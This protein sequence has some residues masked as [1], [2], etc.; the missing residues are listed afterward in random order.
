M[1]K[2]QKNRL[3]ERLPPFIAAKAKANIANNPAI[4]MLKVSHQVIFMK[5]DW[6]SL[7]LNDKKIVDRYLLREQV[8]LSDYNFTNLWMWNEARSYHLA[9]ADGDLCI[10]HTDPKA[11]EIYLMPLGNPV[12]IAAIERLYAEQVKVRKPFAMRA[13]SEEVV[14]H[15][16]KLS[17]SYDLTEE[18]HRFDYVYSY[19]DLANLP[20]NRYQA[21]RNLIHQFERE[22]GLNYRE[23]DKSNLTKIIDCEEIWYKEH[24]MRAED[25]KTEHFAALKALKDFFSL[26][27]KGGALFVG[28]GAVAYSFAEYITKNEL[29]IHVEKALGNYKGAY[30]AINQELLKHFSPV[31]YVN[32]EESLG[33]PQLIKVKDSYHP[34]KF[35][36]KYRINANVKNT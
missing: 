13:I 18:P 30:Q 14:H 27:L 1:P 36:K 34:L 20:G 25:P 3:I 16:K 10:R 8:Q 5:L 12:P 15:L 11:G 23:I 17:F 32:R 33:L 28:E 24:M 31:E 35:L 4:M 26:G 9:E 21:K 2:A 29:L 22:Y 7:T 6:K 19:Q